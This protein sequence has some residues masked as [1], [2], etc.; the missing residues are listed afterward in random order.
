MVIHATIT[1]NTVTAVVSFASTDENIIIPD[2]IVSHNTVNE[3]NSK[4]R[5]EGKKKVRK[6]ISGLK[7]NDPILAYL[8]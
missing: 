6:S 3:V 2:H 7:T 5:T 8:I 1:V 4:G